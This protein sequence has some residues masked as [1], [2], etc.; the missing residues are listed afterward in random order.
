MVFAAVARG[1]DAQAGGEA[2]A[3]RELFLGVGLE[4]G[5]DLGGLGEEGAARAG[6]VL[7]IGGVDLAALEVDAGA[8]GERAA[9][10]FV[11]AG[12]GQAE[13]GVAGELIDDLE[14]GMVEVLAGEGG[15]EADG[16]VAD[17]GGGLGRD[18]EQVEIASLIEG[19]VGG[20]GEGGIGL[21][22]GLG[23]AAGQLGASAHGGEEEAG[24]GGIRRADTEVGE[25][26]PGVLRGVV[27]ETVL[28]RVGEAGVGVE[29][30]RGRAA[31]DGGA[32][33]REGADL[34]AGESAGGGAAGVGDVVDGAAEG[35]AAV[36]E[37]VGPAPDRDVGGGG[38]LDG[39]H[40]EAAVGE[41][42]RHAVL[43]HAHAAPVKGALQAGAADGEAG[44]V[45][46]EAGLGDDA[47]R[48]GEGVGEGGRAA[49]QVAV[50]IDDLDAAGRAGEIEPGGVERRHGE[51]RR[52]QARRGG[53]ERF[54]LDDGLGREPRGRGGAGE[55]KEDT[56]KGHGC[57]GQDGERTGW[58]AAARLASGRRRVRTGGRGDGRA[59]SGWH[60]HAT[61]AAGCGL[62][63]RRG[64]AAIRGA[65]ADLT[66]IR[67]T[68]RGGSVGGAGR[69]QA[70]GWKRSRG[71]A[72]AGAR[73]WAN[74]WA[75]AA[76]STSLPLAAES[77]GAVGAGKVV[78]FPVV[79]RVRTSAT[80]SQTSQRF[81][82]V[83]VRRSASPT[84]MVRL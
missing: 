6:E 79:A 19:E 56:G 2:A 65:K 45:G 60:A 74:R 76:A 3:E 58:E 24:L 14:D 64:F 42:E 37:G 13:E 72:G 7:V 66:E 81:S 18:A 26:A 57:A 34:G 47:G 4:V 27:A 16:G 11:L 9:E 61:G 29:R 52:G 80:N 44:L 38:G 17:A 10:E 28:A 22:F 25:E 46:A 55:G 41:V 54:E 75:G 1:A 43:E 53:F 69:A 82:A 68:A 77:P 84:G 33:V 78:S 67:Q 32:A 31:G 36:G 83:K 49:A 15:D 71:H 62:K 30:A 63:S 40:V 48:E 51:G 73:S 59:P 20:R 23:E 8:E 12:Q 35:G 70:S 39:L 50:G 21:E 5:G